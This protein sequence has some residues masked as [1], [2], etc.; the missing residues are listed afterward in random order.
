VRDQSPHKDGAQHPGGRGPPFDREGCTTP[1]RPRASS[2]LI[3]EFLRG[4]DLF[5]RLSKEIMFTEE[6]VKFYLAEAGPGAEP[7]A[8]PRPSSIATLNR[9]NIL[10]GHIKLTDFGLSKES[11]FDDSSKTYLFLRDSGVHGPRSGKVTV[12]L[13]DWWSYGVAHV[14]D[15]SP[16]RCRSRAALARRRCTRLLKA[17]LAMPQFLSADAQSLLRALFKRNPG[18]RLGSGP[19]GIAELK[20]CSRADDTF[21]F[22]NEYTNRTPQDS[23]CMPPFC[24]G[25]RTV[26]RLLLRGPLLL[27]QQQQNQQSALDDADSIEANDGDAAA[28]IAVKNVCRLRGVKT[29]PFLTDY[30]LK[31]QLGCGSFSEPPLRAQGVWREL[32]CQDYRLRQTRSARRGRNFA[33]LLEHSNIVSL[34]DVYASAGKVYLVMEMLWGKSFFSEREA[35]AV[36]DVV[37]R[38]ISYLHSQGVVCDFG[39]AK[40]LRADNGLLMTPCYTASFGYSAACDV[41][42]AGV[43]LYTML[44]GQTPY[45]H[46]P[47]DPAEE[48]LNRIETGRVELEGGN[49]SPCH[50]LAKSSEIWTTNTPAPQDLVRRMLHV[51]P[52]SASLRPRYCSTPG[53][54]I[55]PLCRC[56]ASLCAKRPA[57]C[58]ALCART[59]AA[60]NSTSTGARQQRPRR[61]RSSGSAGARAAKR[62]SV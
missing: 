29:S 50:P 62:G 7:P 11:V 34:Y 3:L 19:N 10:L 31:E 52:A 26:P 55:V 20:I 51:D 6:D 46:G 32:R 9:R 53:W 37:C 41:W 33:A 2:Y 36:L 28:A 23:P 45:A 56:F 25:Q 22:D 30:E 61:C 42:S 14:R 58:S 5:T 16:A 60:V 40:Q 12:Q 4:G 54:R 39:F 27:T 59:F 1:S 13:S 8:W 24:H 15:A 49:W 17:K 57:R 18:N 44:A 21:Y 35:S 48:I 43:L 38:T 47:A